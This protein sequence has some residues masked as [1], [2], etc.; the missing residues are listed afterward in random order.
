[1]VAGGCMLDAGLVRVGIRKRR[2]WPIRCN[3]YDKSERYPSTRERG[4]SRK[5]FK[6]TEKKFRAPRRTRD[7]SCR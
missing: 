7:S 4:G 6:V 2:R 1:M 3:L 5:I